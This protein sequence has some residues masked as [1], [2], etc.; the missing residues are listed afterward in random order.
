V[1]AVRIDRFPIATPYNPDSSDFVVRI[2]LRDDR[3]V[4]DRVSIEGHDRPS[5]RFVVGCYR[6][7][8]E[9]RSRSLLCVTLLVLESGIQ[10]H[11]FLPP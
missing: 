8:E 11:R 9:T 10:D 2:S 3:V 6:G 5:I 7:L 1:L 4:I